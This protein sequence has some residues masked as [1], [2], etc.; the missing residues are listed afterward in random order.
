MG[1]DKGGY[2]RLFCTCG[3]PCDAVPLSPGAFEAHLGEGRAKHAYLRLCRA[4]GA[5]LRRLKQAPPRPVTAETA[6]KKPR[7]SLTGRAGVLAE[8]A[9]AESS[10]DLFD[11]LFSDN[12]DMDSFV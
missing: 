4:D 1:F 2:L 8:V 3:G 5:S 12:E 11:G 7:L 6:A 9:A 10:A